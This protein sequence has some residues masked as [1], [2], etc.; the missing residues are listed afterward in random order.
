MP[1]EPRPEERQIVEGCLKG[2]TLCQKKL[3]EGFYGKMLGVCQRYASNRDEARDILQD[4]FVKVFQSL[5]NFGFNCPLDAW[6]RRIMVNTAI[7]KYRK[8]AIQPDLYEVDT[9]LDLSSDDNVLD[10][11]SHQE[12]LATI[13]LLPPGYKLVFNMYVIEGFSHKEI[14]GQLEISE[15]TSKSQLAKARVFLQ[16]M[17]SKQY[18]S[19][20]E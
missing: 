3:Y 2:N 18:Y 1:Y 15:G 5:E 14:A 19:E 8:A 16:K 13:Q 6:I 17:I 12:L 20:N 4:G 11:I 10:D 9:V 7:D